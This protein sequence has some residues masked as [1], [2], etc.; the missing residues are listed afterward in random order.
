MINTAFLSLA[1]AQLQER[2]EPD[3][4]YE[5]GA[6]LDAAVTSAFSHQDDVDACSSQAAAHDE[7]S[8]KKGTKE[9]KYTIEQ[10]RAAAL[11]V[12]RSAR[13]GKP[14]P[15]TKAC[16][17]QGAPSMRKTLNRLMEHVWELDSWLERS[18]YLESYTFSQR[19]NPHLRSAIFSADDNAI[20]VHACN[21]AGKA[22]FGLKAPTVRDI[23]NDFIKS[24]Q[25]M[26][27]H[28][29]K[30]HHPGLP[31]VRRWMKANRVHG[32][33]SSSVA[34][35]RARKA[36]DE[37]C[38]HWFNLAEEYIR[39]LH[40]VKRAV[41]WRTYAEVPDHCKYNFDEE[42]ANVEKGRGKTLMSKRSLARLFSI[43]HDGK[44]S[45]HVTDG[46]TTRADGKVCAPYILKAR[47]GKG[48][49]RRKAGESLP[50]L[51]PT[52]TEMRY[53]LDDADPEDD[54]LT[55]IHL[56]ITRSGSMTIEEFPSFC[57]HFNRHVIDAGQ[58]G[59]IVDETTGEVIKEGGEPVLL[60]IDGHASRWADM[61]FY[62]LMQNNIYPICVPSH[63]TIWSQP[64][65]AGCNASFKACFGRVLGE[66][67]EAVA[68]AKGGEVFNKIYRRAFLQWRKE[69][70]Q[71]LDSRQDNAIKSAWRKVGLGGLG[72]A[73]LNPNCLFWRA[74]IEAFGEASLMQSS[75]QGIH[76]AVHA[77]AKAA[78]AAAGEGA[79]SGEDLE[80]GGADDAG[81][82]VDSGGEEGGHH[83]EGTSDDAEAMQVLGLSS[84][85]QLQAERAEQL[86][87]GLRTMPASLELRFANDLE[88]DEVDTP[89]VAA[90]ALKQRGR[91]RITHLADDEVDDIFLEMEQL[92]DPT[93]PMVVEV[94]S[95]YRLASKGVS[96][97]G[98]HTAKERARERQLRLDHAAEEGQRQYEEDLEEL[99]LAVEE[100]VLRDGE[101]DAETWEVVR[102]WHK[103]EPGRV[104]DGVFVRCSVAL[105]TARL[106]EL[107][108]LEAISSK[109][110]MFAASVMDGEGSQKK[111][112]GGSGVN[113]GRGE[114][115]HGAEEQR[116][117][118]REE[119]A[120]RK[121]DAE[122]K[123]A[124][125]AAVKAARM[126]ADADREAAKLDSRAVKALE[127]L[128]AAGGH[129]SAVS[130]TDRSLLIRW[131]GGDVPKRPASNGSDDEL[132]DQEWELVFEGRDPE[133]ELTTWRE[134]EEEDSEGDSEDGEDGEEDEE[135][136]EDEDGE[137]DSE[138][139]EEPWDGE[140]WDLEDG[141]D[142]DDDEEDVEEGD[143]EMEE[144]D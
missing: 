69:M 15:S 60:F 119:Q 7:C 104:I 100:K 10:L 112:R 106:T 29:G 144:E 61:G 138:D 12:L 103:Y 53:L 117:A 83:A 46:M 9:R 42:A 39:Y 58:G 128:V 93:D 98:R 67:G 70:Q 54:E 64:N 22:G 94:C 27:E 75:L 134:Q 96:T 105:T 3:E 80:G 99:R 72:A 121:A 57:E 115:G 122:E 45:K 23:M 62:S 101:L 44:M 136:E 68:A 34:K 20:L 84:T 111:R 1:G 123:A 55:N 41:P 47:G 95:K 74:A 140:G 142:D 82:A 76:R 63:T 125:K 30:L 6:M 120:T 66:S 73:P 8:A 40:D 33:K 36:T 131:Y 65:D 88:D 114:T 132:M 129:F 59:R 87:T 90:V 126:Q 109:I 86:R 32:Y 49:K 78:Q 16:A 37:L 77:A 113:T 28:T 52:N 143:E 43:S 35:E 92:D 31:F 18:D 11:D 51:N 5:H 127:R 139:E 85:E 26:D 97:N 21:M 141:D 81:R 14:L 79:D 50:I 130:R 124:E 38:S 48:G 19:G 71:E 24:S 2:L 17:K 135:G 89:V 137:G 13:L 116:K 133:E 107:T 56:G 25:I 118:W 108:L 91:V 110:A 4:T 102:K